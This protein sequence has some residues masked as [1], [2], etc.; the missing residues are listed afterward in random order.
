MQFSEKLRALRTENQLTQ[1]ELA[2]RIFVTRSAVSKWET[3]GGY[4][5]VD[6][7]KLLAETFGVTL[8]ELISD[9]DV[10]N[11]KLLDDRRARRMYFCAVGCLG[12]T[13]LAAVGSVFLRHSIFAAVSFVGVVGYVVFGLLS[14]PRYKRL[15][16][17]RLL[18]PYII[19]RLVVLAVVI[20]AFIYFYNQISGGGDPWSFAGWT[21][22]IC[23]RF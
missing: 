3:G 11:Q 16:A 2:E 7:L 22:M 13:V 21:G 1:E 5:G 8:D 15:N 20:V 19:S 9:E 17:K 18:L 23:P 10:R 6:S 14:K 4:P 12:V